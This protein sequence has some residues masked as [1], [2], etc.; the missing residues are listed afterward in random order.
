[1]IMIIGKNLDAKVGLIMMFYQSLKNSKMTRLVGDP[2]YHSTDGEWPVVM[3][4][5]INKTAKRFVKSAAHVG[6]SHNADFNDAS[7]LGLGIYKVN[8]DKGTRVNSYRAFIEPIVSRPNLTILTHA[9]VSQ[10]KLRVIL[11]NL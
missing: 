4:Q 3:P 1:M 11:L 5:D 7:Q 10:L 2:Q 6:L 8:Q 9:R